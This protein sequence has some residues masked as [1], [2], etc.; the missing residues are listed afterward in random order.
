MAIHTNKIYT[1]Y[2]FLYKTYLSNEG[3]GDGVLDMGKLATSLPTV[4]D[5]MDPK[6][7]STGE[8]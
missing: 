5:R 3:G 7:C 4:S 6:D 1:S 2:L 8:C